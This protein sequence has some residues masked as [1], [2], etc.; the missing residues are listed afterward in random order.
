MAYNQDYTITQGET[1][2]LY[3]NVTSGSIGQNISGS[4][5]YLTVKKNL[6]DSDAQ[7]VYQSNVYPSTG[8][9]ATLTI[10]SGTTATFTMKSYHYDLWYKDTAANKNALL[11]GRLNIQAA[12]TQRS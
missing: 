8:S 10:P 7:A 4:T 12:V 3:L 11:N 1:F 6:N 9:T 2:N 5:F